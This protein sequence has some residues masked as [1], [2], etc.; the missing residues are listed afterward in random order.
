MNFRKGIGK[1]LSDI[2]PAKK[3]CLRL[4][5]VR[6]RWVRH[7]SP[8][9]VPERSRRHHFDQPKATSADLSVGGFDFAHP[10]RCLNEAEGHFGFIQ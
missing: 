8:T 5:W 3:K 6:L 1:F 10:R 7:R 2:L 4:C 9:G